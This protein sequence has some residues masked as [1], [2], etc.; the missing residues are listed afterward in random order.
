MHRLPR[1]T[2]VSKNNKWRNLTFW[3]FC[4]ITKDGIEPTPM[5]KVFYTKQTF[6]SGVDGPAIGGDSP[7]IWQRRFV[8]FT[9]VQVWE[10][11]S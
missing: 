6:R 2:A 3:R 4:N 1:K 5:A 11:I 10:N 8:S 9:Q 7:I